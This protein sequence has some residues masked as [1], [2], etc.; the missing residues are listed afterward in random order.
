VKPIA[1]DA[2][3]PG[4]IPAGASAFPGKRLRPFLYWPALAAILLVSI[5]ALLALFWND[6]VQLHFGDPDDLMRLQEV[7]DWMAGQ[8]WFDVTQYRVSPP[9]GMPMHWSRLV[10]V[11]IAAMILI[12]RPFVGPV[13]AETFASAIVPMITFACLILLVAATAR[14]V[15]R[16]D[17]L[18]LV[19]AGFCLLDPGTYAV[20]R[21]LHI[22][23]HGWQAVCGMGM[24]LFLVG[25]RHPGRAM[26]AGAFAALWMHISLEGIV[27]TAAAGA[28]LGVRWLLRPTEAGPALPAYLAAAAAT[29]LGLFLVTHGGALFD[30]TF[31]DAVSPVHMVMFATAAIGTTLCLPLARCG[32]VWRVA[33]LGV[34]ALAAGAVYKFW[35]PQCGGGPFASL[36]PLTY[37]YWYQ[38]IGEGLPIWKQP[39]QLAVAFIGAPVFGLIGTALGIRRYGNE[40]RAL[41]IDYGAL[42]AASV[43]IGLVVMR[44]CGFA[45]ILALPGAA[46]LLR[47]GWEWAMRLRMTW[48]RVPVATAIVLLLNPI[49]PVFAALT[50]IPGQWNARPAEPERLAE[51]DGRCMTLDNLHHLDS[52]RPSLFMGTLLISQAM[53]V[54]THHSLVA[55]SYHRDSEAMEDTI[56]FFLADDATAYGIARRYHPDYLFFCAGDNDIWL[57][58]RVAPQG[59]AAQLSKG[60]PPAW[61]VPVKVPG[62]RAAT[63]YRIVH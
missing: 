45:A 3:A 60:A 19:A 11:P 44:A 12:A 18:A 21:P 57:F 23:H 46:L 33:G 24:V 17:V 56:R 49:T 10:D 62:L 61:L 40:H 30:R 6:I 14:R 20:V 52:L 32:L 16:N 31:C 7:R 38:Q 36:G 39:V 55:S 54:A 53:I 8:S 26:L 63:I 42:L 2:P 35:A 9:G 58:S 59:L 25:R 48:A 29:S 15:L 47:E 27:F 28:W 37:R 5:A 22:D 4:Q 1:W 43:A 41:L 34:A 50:L 13:A 51:I